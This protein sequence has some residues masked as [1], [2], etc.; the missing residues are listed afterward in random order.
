ML[1]ADDSQ[2]SLG[3]DE[4]RRLLGTSGTGRVGFTARALPA[5][6]PVQF[7]VREHRLV[8]PAAPSGRLATACRGAVV[9]VQADGHS[10][11]TAWTVEVVGVADVVTDPV[12][13][14]DLDRLVLCRGTRPGHCYIA[15]EMGLISG[16]RVT[17]PASRPVETS[18]DDGRA[19]A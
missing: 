6:Q 17:A 2:E 19:I 8:F 16:W 12:E 3:R 9:V 7:G 1:A 10:D 11:G 13:V 4:C 14:A 18:A 15:V 5:V